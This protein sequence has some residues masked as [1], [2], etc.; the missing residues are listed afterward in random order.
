MTRTTKAQFLQ[1][2]G[3]TNLNVYQFLQ[4]LTMNYY[5]YFIFKARREKNVF[6]IDHLD[7]IYELRVFSNDIF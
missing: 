7:R 4:A 2:I 3:F 5:L 6:E 1:I